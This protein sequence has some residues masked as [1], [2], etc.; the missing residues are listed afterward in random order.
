MNGFA[1]DLRT[2]PGVTACAATLPNSTPNGEL[3]VSL[4]ADHLAFLEAA[5]GVAAYWGYF[6]LFGIGCGTC[7]DLFWWNS[8][9]T[10]RFAWPNEVSGYLA[11]G[12]TGWGDQFAYSIE[13]LRRGDETVF[14]LD[15]VEMHPEELASGFT[16]FMTEEFIRQ[17]RNPYDSVTRLVAENIGPLQWSEHVTHVP[18]LLLGGDDDAEHVQK[19][20]A[21]ASMIINGDI[22]TQSATAPDRLPAAMQTYTDPK[23][24]LRTKLI[25]PA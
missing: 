14:W 3:D 19:L 4:P 13:R 15:S 21:R 11:F 23:G 20:N 8:P 1:Q 22:A 5:N 25:W 24:R 9:D 6:R 10:W 2:L 16:A 12:E 17:A 18:S 7:V